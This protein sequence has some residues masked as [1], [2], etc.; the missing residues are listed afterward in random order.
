MT[1]TSVRETAVGI[2]LRF[3][4]PFKSASKIVFVLAPIG[5]GTHVV[6][7]MR[8]ARTRMSAVTGLFF[9]AEKMIGPD[10][11]RGLAALRRVA[12]R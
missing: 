10:L 8:T 4:R 7:R 3:T 5:T 12:G 11:E 6:W 2:D 9:N 1:I